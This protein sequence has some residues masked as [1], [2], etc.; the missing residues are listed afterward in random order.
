MPPSTHFECPDPLAGFEP[1][2]CPGSERL[3]PRSQRRALLGTRPRDS[4]PG[5]VRGSPPQSLLH[6]W[7]ECHHGDALCIAQPLREP[8][9]AAG[10]LCPL[11]HHLPAHPGGERPHHGDDDKDWRLHTPMYFFL[12]NLSFIDLCHASLSAPKMLAD[13]LSVE[14]TISFGGCVAQLFFLHL[15]TCAEI[16]L[17]T[18]MA[19]DCYVAI[20]HPLQYPTLMSM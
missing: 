20:C 13:L 2:P 16:F 6:G 8:G 3:A 11:L 7:G 4:L 1:P 9:A 10:P 18:V 12:G 5:T 15:C 17:L 19:Y 14:K